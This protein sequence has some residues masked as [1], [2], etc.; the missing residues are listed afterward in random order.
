[1]KLLLALAA[2]LSVVV[3]SSSALA[4]KT[5]SQT[6]YTP[7]EYTEKGQTNGCGISFL[8]VWPG[9]GGEVIGVSGSINF[10]IVP[11]HKNVM[12][13][14]KA[15]AVMNGKKTPVSYAWL[16]SPG[17]GRSADFAKGPAEDPDAFVGAKN[18]DPKAMAL[19]QDLARAGSVF[20]IALKGRALDDS[21]KLP[22]ASQQVQAKVITCFDRLNSH[23]QSVF[24]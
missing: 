24:R 5:A 22:A 19:V 15:T 17:Y 6:E 18:S 8:T 20:G 13:I 21:V 2:G 7:E 11:E 1:M 16:E 12:A 23:M 9:D 3:I 10:F 14:I 4:Q